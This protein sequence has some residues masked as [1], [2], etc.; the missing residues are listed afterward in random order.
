MPSPSEEPP[1]HTETSS[2]REAELART[3]RHFPEAPM[4]RFTYDYEIVRRGGL[5]FA[6]AAFLVGLLVIFS[7]RFRCGGKPKARPADEEEP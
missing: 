2:S 1:S 3:Q 6:A 5:I 7:R 4:D